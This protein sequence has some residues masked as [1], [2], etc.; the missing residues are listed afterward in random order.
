MV[1]VLIQIIEPTPITC[2]PDL[3]RILEE[4]SSRNKTTDLLVDMLIKPV[5]MNYEVYQ[6]RTGRRLTTSS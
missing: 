1:E 6:S 4:L 5:Y 2:K 3:M